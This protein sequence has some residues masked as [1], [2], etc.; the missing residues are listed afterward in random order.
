MATTVL[1]RKS[2]GQ[3]SLVGYSSW[4]RTI[5]TRLSEYKQQPPPIGVLFEAIMKLGEK[6]ELREGESMN[7]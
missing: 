4:G 3:R 2:H 7:L 5:Q 1:A 6:A